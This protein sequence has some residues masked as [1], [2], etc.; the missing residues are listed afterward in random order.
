[1]DGV[2]PDLAKKILSRDFANLAKRVHTGG[3]HTRAERA[4]LQAM[5]AGSEEPAVTTAKSQVELAA[6]LGI[7]R[8]ALHAW[9]KFPD[10]P[11]VSSNGTYDVLAWR[12]FVKRR[13]LK[14]P[15]QTDPTANLKARRL[16]ADV[17]ERELRIAI[18]KAEI[19]P[20]SKVEEEWHGLVGKA[21]ALLRSKFE[22][23]LPPVLAG[24]DA[25]GIQVECRRAIDAVLE[26][27]SRP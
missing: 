25:H 8:Q 10:A 7:T 16:L 13:G 11:K 12:E 15:Q 2:S 6:A 19:V 5:A 1:M 22:Q 9:K 14:T 18:K 23:E 26:V 3:K 4:M 17:E 20:V 21:V 24:L 27:L